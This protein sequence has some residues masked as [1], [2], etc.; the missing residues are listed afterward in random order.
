MRISTNINIFY[1]CKVALTGYR[2]DNESRLHLINKATRF[3][4]KFFSKMIIADFFFVMNSSKNN[5]KEQNGLEF[6]RVMGTGG[7]SGFSL[8][9]DFSTY[10]IL[11]VWKNK[12]SS[13]L[14]FK[15]HVADGSAAQATRPR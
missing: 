14:F 15:S 1:D 7:G 6:I 10:A 2:F 12:N 3:R 4:T 13:E 8:R 5:F 9:P 11:C